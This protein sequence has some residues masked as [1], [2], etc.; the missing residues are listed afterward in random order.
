MYVKHVLLHHLFIPLLDLIQHSYHGII[1]TLFA[2]CP[3]H[4]HQQ[5]L[6]RD[7]FAFIQCVGPFTQGSMETG[8][9]VGAHAGLIILLKKGIYIEVPKRVHHLHPWIGQLKDQHIQSHWHQLFPLPTPSVASVPTA[10]AC[11]LTHSGVTIRVW[12]SPV[13][14]GRGRT[15]STNCSALGLWWPSTL[16]HCPSIGDESCVSPLSHPRGS[17]IL[18]RCTPYQLARVVRLLCHSNWYIMGRVLNSA[19]EPLVVGGSDEP[20]PHLHQG[21]EANIGVG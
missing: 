12:C 9:D 17:P 16:S 7:V 18:L 6:H 10:V 15:P 19:S 3:F 14:G 20:P 13:W 2:K 11:S 8:R 1:V 4:V 21:E 5:V